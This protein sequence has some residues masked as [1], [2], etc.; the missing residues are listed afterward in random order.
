MAEVLVASRSELEDGQRVFAWV[1]GVQIGVLEHDGRLYAFENRCS[2]Q[3][4]PVCEGTVSGRVEQRFDAAGRTSGY[5]FSQR[6]LH[7]VC[8][9]H[10]VEFELETG[11]C[12]SDRRR[13]IRRYDV[14]ERD[15]AVYVSL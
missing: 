6:E 11:R 5:G 13:R 10:G 9:W 7:L 3:G 12:T 8:P 2:H 15:G 14:H 4:G 1:D